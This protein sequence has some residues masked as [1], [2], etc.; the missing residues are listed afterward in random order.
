MHLLFC[1]VKGCLKVG[2]RAFC[3]PIHPM[4]QGATPLNSLL[5][6]CILILFTACAIVQFSQLA[7]RDYARATQADVVFNAQIAYLKFYNFFFAKKVFLYLLV[8]WCFLSLIYLTFNPKDRPAMTL[9]SAKTDK[10]MKKII[11][12]STGDGRV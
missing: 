7:F 5:F 1:T 3:L 6:N 4:R 9:G 10:Q 8:V 12:K 2:M 11:G